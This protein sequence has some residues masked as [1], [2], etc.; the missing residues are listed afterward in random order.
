MAISGSM[1]DHFGASGSSSDPQEPSWISSSLEDK[2]EEVVRFIRKHDKNAYTHVND[3][4][5]ENHI[6]YSITSFQIYLVFGS[7]TNELVH[8][9]TWNLLP[10]KQAVF[11]VGIIGDK[12]FLRHMIK[13]W[14]QHYPFYDLMYFRKGRTVRRK[15][16]NIL[17]IN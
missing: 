10:E 7:E 15:N 3:E 2:V 1:P 9:A 13:Q 17:H 14:Q 11:L 12:E 8:V 16:T 4:R 5:L 6:R